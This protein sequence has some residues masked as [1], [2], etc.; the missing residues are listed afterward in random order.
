MTC[1]QKNSSTSTPCRDLS[2][3]YLDCRMEKWVSESFSIY[4][5]IIRRGSMERDDWKNLGMANLETA[6][7]VK[8]DEN[9]TKS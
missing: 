4:L 6:A 2:K 9:L 7:T 3:K 1:L 8:A 5:L